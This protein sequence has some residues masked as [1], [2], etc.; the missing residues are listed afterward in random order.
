MMSARRLFR[1]RQNDTDLRQEME[2]HLAEE[3]AENIERA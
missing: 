1:R 3:I 2:M